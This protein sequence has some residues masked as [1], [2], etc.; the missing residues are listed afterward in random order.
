VQCRKYPVFLAIESPTDCT[1]RKNLSGVDGA[2]LN[3]GR[4]KPE[5]ETYIFH[6][7]K[8]GS[9]FRFS[10]VPTAGKC[11]EFALSIAGIDPGAPSYCRCPDDSLM[12]LAGS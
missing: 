10:F 6:C 8:Y 11:A 1:N 4:R 12:I 2:Q 7:A 5:L 9:F 3:F